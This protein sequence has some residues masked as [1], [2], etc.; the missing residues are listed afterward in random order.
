[1]KNKNFIKIWS[2]GIVTVIVLVGIK[3]SLVYMNNLELKY[4]PPKKVEVKVEPKIKTFKLYGV[5]L[6]AKNNSNGRYTGNFLSFYDKVRDN[7][8]ILKI[9]SY[10][11]WNMYCVGNTV[12]VEYNENSYIENIKIKE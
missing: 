8:I 9:N 5:K 6:V 2:M 3:F 7:V 11:V 10:E 4:N 12:D 1:M